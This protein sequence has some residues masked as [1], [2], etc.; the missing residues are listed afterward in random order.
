MKVSLNI[1]KQF[2]DLDVHLDPLEI[3]DRLSNSGFEIEEVIRCGCDI[4]GILIGYVEERKP[5]PNADKLSVCQVNLGNETVQIVCGA[6]NVD[7]G[8]KVP[9]ATS[10]TDLGGGFVIKKTVLRGE[11][12]NGMI[13]SEQELGIGSDSDGIMVLETDLKP[14]T[15]FKEYF[16]DIDTVYDIS[17]T[18]NRPDCISHI[19]IARELAAIYKVSFKIPEFKFNEGSEKTDD[20]FSLQLDADCGCDRFTARVIKNVKI[21]ESPEWLKQ[22]LNNL[23]L[24]PINN[25]VDISNYVMM[26]TGQPMHFYDYDNVK[27]QLLK[28]RSAKEEETVVTLDEK[29]RKLTKN[30]IVIEDAER[31]AGLGGVMGGL[32]TEVE[33]DTKN[34]LI[35]AAIWD[36]KRIQRIQGDLKFFTDASYRYSKSVDYHLPIL[37]QKRAAQ[38]IQELCGGDIS[39]DLIDMS[40]KDVNPHTVDFRYERCDQ[41]LGKTT[42]RKQIDDIFQRLELTKLTDK[43]WQ[44][45]TFR[46]DLT[47]EV[48]LIEEVARLIGLNTIEGNRDLK[49]QY[50]IDVN[51]EDEF[52]DQLKQ[53]LV[54]MG[55]QEIISNSMVN[56]KMAMDFQNRELVE[57]INPLS[58]E[59]DVMRSS[60]IPSV[61]RVADFNYRHKQTNLKLFEINKDYL[62]KKRKSIERKKLVV[63]LSGEINEKH[64]SLPNR[65]VD[66][67]DIK[68]LAESLFNS[69][70]IEQLNFA[71]H[72]EAY[73]SP[74]CLGLV[75][76]NNRIGSIGKIDQ[77]MRKK[78]KLSMDAYILELSI[79]ELFKA[80]QSRKIDIRPISKFPVVERDVAVL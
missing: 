16:T 76:N 13:C 37:A 66:F 5:H 34:V 42:D 4:E 72:N 41:L 52:I 73:F 39:N 26:E 8:Q 40:S 69:L 25:L 2:V 61:L 29:K 14:G 67:Y 48:D 31:F 50:R 22:A 3:A 45:P 51:E 24:R 36:A 65:K 80:A 56:K 18:P 32:D 47:R 35:E 17:I 77:A 6:P 28:V 75:W 30:C 43:Q 71:E 70:G 15:P 62:L 11:E 38:L 10:G 23:G 20:L 19:G 63:L 53:Q 33:S 46:Q 27:G 21:S 68:G 9:V 55:I 79:S 59:M 74:E 12:S 49:I 54:D 64:W 57:I 78:L 58:D 44:V 60:L 7:A 1:L